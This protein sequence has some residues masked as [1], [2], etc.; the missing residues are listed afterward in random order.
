M[1]FYSIHAFDQKG[2][3][4]LSHIVRCN[5]DLDALSAGIRRSRTHA[6][7]IWQDDRFVARVKLGNAPLAT[8]DACSL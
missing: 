4:A 8:A 2:D 3:V 5:D 7:E 1:S 6:I